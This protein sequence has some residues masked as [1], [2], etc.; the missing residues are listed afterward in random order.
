MTTIS[1]ITPTFNREDL[2]A[3]CV[4]SVLAQ[5]VENARI[6][7]IV[8]NDYGQPLQRAAA[9]R[10]DPRT[11][12]VDT[13][14]TERSVAR[15]TGAAL[16]RG[17]WLF[18][19]DDDDYVLPGAFAALL[20]TA[21]QKPNA[22]EVYG[23][24]E[25][26]DV[27]ADTST[28]IAPELPDD[29]SA[30]FLAGEGLPPQA[31]WVRRAAFF[32]CGGFDPL[33]VP[34]ED[35]DLYRRVGFVGPVAGTQ[36]VVAVAHV[37]APATSTSDYSHH[38]RVFHAGLEKSLHLPDLLPRI[39]RTTARAPYWR[40]RCAREYLASA[41]RNVR[42]RRYGTAWSRLTGAGWLALSH[43]HAPAFWRGVR[44]RSQA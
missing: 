36:S 34:A 4:E 20:E 6:E 9:W 41:F 2:L 28:I 29:S 5:Q 31:T 8:V 3:R 35:A 23:A 14:R 37:N 13:F 19:L 26:R 12:V 18:F 22:A 21:R 24:Y 32:A 40:G 25:V 1:V 27:T 30:L 39:A 38:Q 10:D 17:D 42:A 16:S 33:V 15:N 11:R 43:L 44:R 7:H